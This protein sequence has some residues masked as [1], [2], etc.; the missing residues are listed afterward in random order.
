VL[1]RLH[2]ATVRHRRRILGC[3][4][5]LAVLCAGLQ[6]PS[7]AGSDAVGAF[8]L[9]I[10]LTCSALALLA[11]GATRPAAFVVDPTGPA[12]RTLPRAADVYLAIT[13]FMIA[14]WYL[15]ALLPFGGTQQDRTWHGVIAVTWLGI[16]AFRTTELL[17][18]HGLQL[19]P[20]GLVDSG[21]LGSLFVPWD[22][23]A[24]GGPLRPALRTRR[25]PLTYRHPELVRR[26]GVG[27]SRRQV[28]VESVHPWFMADVIRHYVDHP[29]HRISIGTRSE[30]DRLLGE[31]IMPYPDDNP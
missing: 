11:F 30:Y 18:D 21:V 15:P 5:G 29:A 31:L 9:V 12:L 24:P 10:V 14:S 19:H 20:E 17:R 28:F 23:F 26:R 4:A 25:L 8:V 27:I 22:A 16:A 6:L 2:A 13:T 1:T 7:A 3:A